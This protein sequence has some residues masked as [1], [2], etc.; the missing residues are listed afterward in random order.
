MLRWGPACLAKEMQRLLLFIVASAASFGVLAQ[1][2]SLRGSKVQEV[3]ESERAAAMES[4]QTGGNFSEVPDLAFPPAHPGPYDE[5]PLDEEAEEPR[6]ALK[7]WPATPSDL[8]SNLLNLQAGS[9]WPHTRFCD[10]HHTGYFCN[11]YTRV[12]CCRSNSWFVQC[13]TTVHSSRCGYSPPGPFG[14]P[15]PSGPWHIHAGWHVNSF[16]TSHSVGSFCWNHKR[17]HCC[18]DY[19]H[20]VECNSA[21][22]DSRWC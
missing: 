14:P 21:Y 6:P 7:D 17:T 2:A 16:C 19:G 18:N 1:D 9:Y 20:I 5:E 4:S 3:N 15:G 11:G 13:G 12:K 22:H 10:A 8:S